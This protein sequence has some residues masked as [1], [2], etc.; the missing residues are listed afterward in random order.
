MNEERGQLKTALLLRVA[1]MECRNG[2]DF[3]EYCKRV[4]DMDEFTAGLMFEVIDAAGDLGVKPDVL[5]P[6][7]ERDSTPRAN[8]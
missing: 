1:Y 4:F 3:V 5:H 6:I 2:I 7:L 8:T